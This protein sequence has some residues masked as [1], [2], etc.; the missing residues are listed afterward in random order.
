VSNGASD[1]PQILREYTTSADQ[2]RLGRRESDV[3]HSARWDA[4]FHASLPLDIMQRLA[5]SRPTDLKLADIADLSNEQAD[6]R[7]WG[8]GTF[9]YIEISDVDT[10]TSAVYSKTIPCA[11]APSRARKVV[12]AGDVLVSTVRPERRAVGAVRVDQDGAI[13]TTGFAVLRPK[14]VNALTLA[15]L[16]KTDFVNAQL[17]RCNMGIAY[18]AIDERSLL[19][20]VIPVGFE[21]IAAIDEHARAIVDLEERLRLLRDD[22]RATVESA[23]SENGDPS[24]PTSAPT[25]PL[26]NRPTPRRERTTSS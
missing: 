25:P 24:Q 1:L 11:E 5:H 6:P 18:P 2:L 17:R 15:Y 19:D 4:T 8:H 12:H 14:G 23:A 9:E 7:R 26:S 22:F 10:R 16:L 20:V 3:E 21:D 13:C